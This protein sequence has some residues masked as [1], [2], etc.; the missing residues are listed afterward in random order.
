MSPEAGMS[1]AEPLQATIEQHDC[2]AASET[3]RRTLSCDGVERV[4][5]HC[6]ICETLW[7]GERVRPALRWKYTVAPRPT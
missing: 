7:Q 6:T 1:L 4:L 5:E 3:L 2:G